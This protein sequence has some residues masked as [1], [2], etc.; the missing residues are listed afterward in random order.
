M[1]KDDLILYGA[2]AVGAYLLYK[3]TIGQPWNAAT[4]T[5]ALEN[6]G[7]TVIPSTPALK[8]NDTFVRIGNTSFGFAPSDWQKLN[9]AQQFIITLD[10]IVPGTFLTQWALSPP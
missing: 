3:T 8:T 7:G 2:V 9:D 10:S 4:G 6:A 1:N 5:Q